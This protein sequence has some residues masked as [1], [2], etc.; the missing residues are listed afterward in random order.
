MTAALTCVPIGGAAAVVYTGSTP[1]L[2]IC[3]LEQRAVG[4]QRRL[5]HAG[6]AALLRL[7]L[8]AQPVW[9]DV[10]LL[11]LPG[12]ASGTDRLLDVV[13]VAAAAAPVAMPP[14]ATSGAD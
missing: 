12:S 2:W 4:R 6:A 1:G 14:L 5:P 10:V 13:V 8:L 3:G 9:W 11:A 7:A